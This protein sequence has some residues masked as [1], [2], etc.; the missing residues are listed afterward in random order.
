M[1]HLGILYQL[2]SSTVQQ[3]M[4]NG[5]SQNLVTSVIQ[6]GSRSKEQWQAAQLQAVKLQQSIL[7]CC[8]W[9][10][11]LTCCL[12]DRD[13]MGLQTACVPQTTHQRGLRRG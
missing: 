6:H 5:C 7:N 8:G 9:K 2:M 11:G 3:I 13:S 10:H 4:R 1:H 12:V